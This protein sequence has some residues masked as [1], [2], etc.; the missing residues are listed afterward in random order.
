[1]KTGMRFSV[2]AAL[3]FSRAVSPASASTLGFESG[4]FAGWNVIIP[5]YDTEDYGPQKVGGAYVKT[6][7]TSWWN[8]PA[9]TPIEG[10]YLAEFVVDNSALSTG[11]YVAAQHSFHLQLGDTLNGWAAFTTEDD[12]ASDWA[13]ARVYNADGSTAATP[14]SAS[15]GFDGYTEH[16]L[17]WTFWSWT[18][19]ASGNFLLELRAGTGGDAEM[20]SSALFDAISVSKVPDSTSSILLVATGLGLVGLLFVSQRSRSSKRHASR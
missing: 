11:G 19:P 15:S 18:A 17:P 7:G 8:Y 13:F 5:T 3:L 1:M 12:F 20:G 4:D 10:R 6:T 14:W 16:G 9:Y 2:L